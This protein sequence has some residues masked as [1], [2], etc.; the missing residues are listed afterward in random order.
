[1]SSISFVLEYLATLFCFLM[2]LILKKCRNVFFVLFSEHNKAKL[3]NVMETD[4]VEDS[5][6]LESCVVNI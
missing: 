1:M 6:M 3:N 5:F 2:E 4:F